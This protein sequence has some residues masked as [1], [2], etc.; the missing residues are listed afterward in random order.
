MDLSTGNFAPFKHGLSS[1]TAKRQQ[2]TPWALC[3]SYLRLSIM[4]MTNILAVPSVR[5]FGL[6]SLCIQSVD[7]MRWYPAHM[8]A[9]PQQC[10]GR[11]IA[12]SGSSP[13]SL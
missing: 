8:A 9:L 7:C 5:R 13:P 12:G 6:A 4:I 2:G 11:G 1:K 10:Q 3:R